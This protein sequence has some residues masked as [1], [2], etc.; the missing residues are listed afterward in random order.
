ML[1][2]IF[3]LGKAKAKK[4]QARVKKRSAA[5]RIRRSTITNNARFVRN[6]VRMA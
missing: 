6:I 2:W 1:R 3:G 4:L 5:A